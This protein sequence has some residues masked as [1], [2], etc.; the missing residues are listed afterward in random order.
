MDDVQDWEY[1]KCLETITSSL[2]DALKEVT[3]VHVCR[4]CSLVSVMGLYGRHTSTMNI[5]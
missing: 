2:K 3:G 1:E 4:C 5:N